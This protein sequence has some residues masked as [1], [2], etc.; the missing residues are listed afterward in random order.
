[1][2]H[3]W[4]IIRQ[5]RKNTIG[6][7][8]LMG[9]VIYLALVLCFAVVYFKSHSIGNSTH[10]DESLRFMDAFYFSF[11]SFT[12]IGYGDLS[13]INDLGK[14]ILFLETICS[15]LFN[16]MFPSILIY[17]ALKRPRSIVFTSHLLIT[18]NDD[19]KFILK[20]RIANRGSDIINC[21]IAF[22]LFTFT[23]GARL[24]PYFTTDKY[25]LLEANTVN[26]ASICLEEQKNGRLLSELQT[27]F[28]DP[29]ATFT[30]RINLA[31][32]DADTGTTVALSRYYSE[33]DI[34]FGYKFR[35]VG[36]WDN[37]NVYAPIWDN[38]DKTV[39][40]ADCKMDTFLKIS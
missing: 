22:N 27:L 40:D 10:T 39:P 16:G 14:T 24:K 5:S 8:L 35:L 38:F 12:T 31:G 13:P 21:D 4:N 30:M 6:F 29:K 19:G 34:T 17:Y 11:V 15:V 36:F 18:R 26:V 20:L 23:K 33:K 25:P 28:E 9:V 1:M 2:S 37:D 3:F 7:V 32:I